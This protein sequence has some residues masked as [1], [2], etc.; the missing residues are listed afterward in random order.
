MSE[1]LWWYVARASGMV[2]AVLLVLTLIWGLLLTT[3]LIDRRGLPAWLTD[4]HRYLG[5]LS[6]VFIAVHMASLVFDSYMTF[7]WAELFVPFASSWKAGPV[8]WG[9]GAF[10]GLVVVEGTSLLQRRMKRSWWR[11]LHHLSYPVALM[12]A[13]HAAQAGTDASNPV[14]RVV[15]IGLVAVLSALTVFR[16]LYSPPKR[17][18]VTRS[19]RPASVVAPPVTGG[20]TGGPPASNRET[21]LR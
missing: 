1:Q 8:A 15:T 12:A 2:A 17:S 13:L 7:S 19:T 21:A 10:W 6:V 14:F 11:G 18:V 20:G 4:L 9:V 16:I 3:K 5:G